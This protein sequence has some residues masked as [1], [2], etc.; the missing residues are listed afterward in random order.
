M[1][2]S[3]KKPNI[4][5]ITPFTAKRIEDDTKNLRTFNI[6]QYVSSKTRLPKPT[7][8]FVD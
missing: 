5:T 4:T 3:R 1:V 2:L 6:E 7:F 8:R